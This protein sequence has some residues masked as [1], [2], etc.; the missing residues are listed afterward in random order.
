MLH[1]ENKIRTYHTTCAAD[2]I[3]ETIDYNKTTPEQLAEKSG[4]SLS[5]ISNILNKKQFLNNDL[6]LKI[7][8]TLNVSGK[9]LFN[10]DKDYQS[11][12]K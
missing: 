1:R 10:L 9:F 6:A 5:V 11:N 7:G 12:L 4:I 8:R 3:K 2:L